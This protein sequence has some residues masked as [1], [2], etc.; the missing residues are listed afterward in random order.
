M[1]AAEV[2]NQM[3]ARRMTIAPSTVKPCLDRVCEKYPEVV[4]PARTRLELHAIAR[5]EGRLP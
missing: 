5:R 3:G 2:V 1:S 4:L